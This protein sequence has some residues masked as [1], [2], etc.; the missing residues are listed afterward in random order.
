MKK[1]NTIGLTAILMI[2]ITAV[3]FAYDGDDSPMGGYGGHHMM[4]PGY[5]HHMMEPGYRR[6]MT[7]YDGDCGP[8]L[9]GDRGWGHLSNKDAAKLNTS[10]EKF[11]NDTHELQSKLDEKQDELRHAINQNNPDR[12]KVFELQKQVSSLQIEFDQKALAHRLEM[13]KLLPDD[14]RT[15]GDDGYCW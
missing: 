6:H 11:Y 3:A 15:S 5:G 10:R 12:I 14:Y 4:E 2:A 1:L 9:H 7:V 8:Y 13:R